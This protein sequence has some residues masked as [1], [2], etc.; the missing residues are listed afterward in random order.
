MFEKDNET[1]AE[2]IIQ[3][4]KDPKTLWLIWDPHEDRLKYS[5]KASSSE[6]VT[7]RTI[8]SKIA[9][10]FDPLGLVGPAIIRAKI[11]M[12]KLWQLQ[13]GWDETLPQDIH[14]MWLDFNAQLQ[15]LNTISV[16]RFVCCDNFITTQ[17]HGF[18]DASEAAYGACIYLRTS[19]ASGQVAVRLLCAKSRVA[20]LKTIS[21][22]RLELQAAVLL[23]QLSET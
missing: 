12:Q 20:P 16:L 11:I 17:L 14:T 5:I 8:L 19:T 23:S 2:K 6:R 10:I 13:V 1:S 4:D 3:S 18:C 15:A 9:Q 22:P 7:K 21:V